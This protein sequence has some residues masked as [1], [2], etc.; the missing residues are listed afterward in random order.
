MVAASRVALRVNW[1]TCGAAARLWPVFRSLAT[2]PL[3]PLLTTVPFA[4]PLLISPLSDPR[5]EH[6]L[7]TVSFAVGVC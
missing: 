7:S 2:A 3:L 4:R 6:G 5:Q 1:V